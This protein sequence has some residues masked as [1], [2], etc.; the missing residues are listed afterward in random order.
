MTT[1]TNMDKAPLPVLEA[2]GHANPLYDTDSHGNIT[3]EVEDFSMGLSWEEKGAG[4]KK[5]AA[6][7]VKLFIGKQKGD[8]ATNL[9]DLDAGA[10]FF[11]VGNKPTKYLGFDNFNPFKD[12]ME[13]GA[14]Q[15]AVHSGDNQTG[16]GDGDDETI[17]LRLKLIPRRFT[18]ILIVVGA[19]KKGSD[20]EA[21]TD[22]KATI[23]DNTGGTSQAMA[24]IEPSLLEDKHIL[25][26]ARLDRVPGTDRWT[27]TVCDGSFNITQGDMKS[28]LRASMNAM[29][30]H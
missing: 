19:F 2:D 6:D 22:M 15:S 17:T 27:L 20:V 18:R 5:K 7:R 26:V 4:Q 9:S 21:T 28:L 24:V 29:A 14:A 11:V 25:P 3:S 12:E 10:L 23:Y 8:I 30:A 1:N 13:P 16:A